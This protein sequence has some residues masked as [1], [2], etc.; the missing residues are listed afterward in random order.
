MGSVIASLFAAFFGIATVGTLAGY[1]VTSWFLMMVFRKAG[2]I[3]DWRAWVPFYNVMVYAKLGDFSPWVM[4]GAIV[5]E[6][7]FGSGHGLVSGLIS[8]AALAAVVMASWRIGLKL[9]QTWPL[10]LL[11]ILPGIGALIWLGILAFDSSRWNVVVPPAPWARNSFFRDNT[12]WQGIPLQT[13]RMPVE[14]HHAES[15]EKEV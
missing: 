14:W 6:V 11:W 15:P 3:G 9:Q 2:V 10:L 4:L 1:V 12:Q 13:G 7:L 5:L 8:L